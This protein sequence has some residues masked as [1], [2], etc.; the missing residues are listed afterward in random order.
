M[1]NPMQMLNLVNNPVGMM[2]QQ[3]QNNPMFKRAQE[4]AQGKS[5][6]EIKQICENLCQ[7]R[8]I[9]LNSAVGMFNSQFNGR[10]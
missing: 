2:A 8:G 6:Q 4:M 9:D 10:M 1:F 7:Q 5:E 3:F